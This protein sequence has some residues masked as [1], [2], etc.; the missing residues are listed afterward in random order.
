MAVD[1]QLR[2]SL[3]TAA[4]I[5][6]VTIAG[7]V[8]HSLALRDSQ[9]AEADAARQRIELRAVQLDHAVA[10]QLDAT[11]R[12]IDTALRHLRNVYVHDRGGFDRAVRD[13]LAAYPQGM[14]QFVTVYGPD[15]YLAYSSTPTSERLYFGDREHFRVHT[16]AADDLFFVS[17]PV[18]GRITGIPLIVLTR[19]IRQGKQL[20][21]VVAIPLR[22][23]YLANDLGRLRVY[24]TDTLAI[25][26]TDGSII[27]RSHHLDEALRTIVPADRPYLRAQPGERGLFRS[28][29]AVDKVPLL[30]SW[31]R[32]SAWPLSVVAAID[33]NAE[34]MPLLQRQEGE[35]QR[36]AWAMALVLAFAAGV[37]ALLVRVA[38]K[39]VEAARSEARF[40]SVVD[41]V[42]EVIFQTDAQGLW[43]FLSQAWTEITGFGVADSLGK[44]FLD[45]VH[46][47]DRER[48]LALFEP[49]I[50]RK[51]DYCRHEIRY[52]HQDGGFRWIEVFARLTLDSQDNI[53]GTSGTLSD[54]TERK[55][56]EQSASRASGLLQEAITSIPQGFTI[57]DEND[58]LVICND[59]YLEFYR[60]SRDLIVPGASFEEIV[61][62]GAE[63]GQYRDAIGRVDEW[64]RDRVRQHLAADGGLYEQQLD[65][66]RWLLIIEHR[67]PSGYIVGNRIDITARKELD[68]EL[69]RHRHHLEGLVAERTAALS[70]A[71]DA[72]EAANRAKTTF[73][74]NMSHELRTPLNAII[75]M[76]TLATRRATD[77][78]QADHLTKVAQA[79]RNLLAIINDVLDIS[80]IEAERLHLQRVDFRLRGV[81][82]NL[83]SLIAVKAAE[84][85]LALVIDV[86]PALADLPLRGDPL[87]LGQVLLN[88]AGNAVK[89]TDRGSV[90]VRAAIAEEAAAAV[91][92]R[93]EVVDTGIGVAAA[94][95]PRLFLA[96]EQA[97]GSTTRR[98]GGTG[99]GLAISKRLAW[100]MDGDIGVDSQPG[101]GSTFWFTA[102]LE[103]SGLSAEGSP[104]P[105]HPLVAPS[106]RRFREARILLVEDD[107]INQ[108][109][110]LGLLQ[111]A[112][113]QVDLAVN[114]RE[115]IDRVMARGYRL[116]LMD[117]RMPVLDGLE[118]TRA[119][120]RLP[121]GGTVPIVAMTASAFAEERQRCLD[122]GMD[123]VLTKP[124]E[125]DL[126]YAT[127][128]ALLAP[129]AP[130]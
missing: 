99:L 110:A 91:V 106:L 129:A 118:A 62:R 113:L 60:T 126:L 108:E 73:L 76:T 31:Q 68:A 77:P 67:T 94:D 120:R 96:F 2:R 130:G 56:A 65:D 69:E 15:G 48:N 63:R 101:E 128:A 105:A 95:L 30:F 100:M 24:P 42:K 51:K 92:L 116:I 22:P 107:P 52:L 66:G 35:R 59:A 124:V 1:R 79:S 23:D 26:R 64:V 81:L 27:A 82:E 86:A 114:G 75:G 84:K 17:K 8:Y 55:E 29:S 43:T 32:L 9:V 5:V 10:L 58:R 47:A 16:E 123:E 18:V 57:Y 112:G 41:N 122:A 36:T 117:V 90:T 34:L 13:V 109:V 14:L 7:G 102:R 119:I 121:A 115:A 19:A 12:S 3:A 21:G 61:R 111:D 83:Q 11:L 97:D 4:L 70:V 39:N 104:P 6:G 54:I 40:R 87:R 85:G 37:A 80:K 28:V 74:A 93:F 127:L 89:F 46:P 72:A 49:L 78:V 103:Q 125:P 38:R 33:E 20:I 44:A 53:V 71:K 50:Q 88:L 45:Y 25:A 98:F